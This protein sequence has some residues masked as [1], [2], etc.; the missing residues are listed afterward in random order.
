MSGV[1]I[2]ITG[3]RITEYLLQALSAFNRGEEEIILR[4]IGNSASKAVQIATILQKSFNCKLEGSGV[5]YFQFDGS[6][7]AYLELTISRKYEKEYSSPP[8]PENSKFLDFYVYQLM[9][10]SLLNDV[11]EFEVTA[12]IHGE[13]V[14]LGT[15]GEKKGILF[16]ERDEDLNKKGDTRNTYYGVRSALYRAGMLMPANWIEI[17]K[18]LSSYD[19]VIL[20]VDTNILINASIS[21]H[22]VPAL[23]LA[24]PIDYAHTPNWILLV[25]PSTVMYELEGKANVR[26]ERGMIEHYGRQA[27]RALEE[28]IELNESYD[29]QGISLVIV[30]ETDPV[31]ETK[32]EIA[33]L[34]QDMLKLMSKGESVS[35][36]HYRK[37]SSGDIIIRDQFKNF[38]RK[39]DFHKGVYFITSDKSNAALADAEGLHSIYVKIPAEGSGYDYS[40]RKY[41]EY[42]VEGTP[43]IKISVPIGKLIYEFAVEF[44]K[45]YLYYEKNGEKHKIDINIDLLG[46]KIDHWVHR[47]LQIN[48]YNYTHHLSEAKLRVDINK[49]REVWYR[50]NKSI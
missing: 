45:I 47:R 33:G 22:L 19:D 35:T 36:W 37:S 23:N 38:I 20:G 46:E 5:G 40:M 39:I 29:I 13:N 10:D 6:Q 16:F 50:I 49:I 21:E 7:T 30:G 12:D 8:Y 31:L 17:A 41:R 28:I 44:G 1:I 11:G 34:R 3:K 48:K 42:V 27:F 4:G 26:D 32:V 25:I 15:I 43:Q 9:F 24:N 18:R 14:K 2:D